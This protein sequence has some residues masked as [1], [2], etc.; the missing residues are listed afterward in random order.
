MGSSVR[1]LITGHL[2]Y[3]GVEMTDRMTALDYEVVGLDAGYFEGCDFIAP[4]T[5][6]PM[7]G[8]DLRD[9]TPSHLSG[10]DAVVHLGALSN[11]PLSDLN[12]ALTYDINLHASV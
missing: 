10:F 3:I 9:V 8:V 5:P 11:D 7:L 12:P 2:G 4:P 1:V 6:V